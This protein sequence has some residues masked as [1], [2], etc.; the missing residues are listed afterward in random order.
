[1]VEKRCAKEAQKMS[2]EFLALLHSYPDKIAITNLPCRGFPKQLKGGYKINM[3]KLLLSLLVMSA[4]VLSVV[5]GVFAVSVGSGIGV[6][7]TTEDFPP[8]VWQCD[9][10]VVYDDATEPGRISEDG[11]EL[12]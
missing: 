9:H 10:R 3:K 12:V 7:I 6:D 4:L 2:V 1:M 8:I 11:Q 5:P